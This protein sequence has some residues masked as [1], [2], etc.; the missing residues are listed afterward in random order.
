MQPKILLLALATT[1]AAAALPSPDSNRPAV[2]DARDNHSPAPPAEDDGTVIEARA[3]HTWTAAG[4]CKTDWGG[5]CLNTCKS[6]A[7]KKG[8]DCKAIN[9]NIWKG[10]CWL[11]WSICDC[12]CKT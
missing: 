2:V 7:K 6:E 12:G 9:D 10:D 3:T 8:Y 5:K 11:G 1:A 4:G